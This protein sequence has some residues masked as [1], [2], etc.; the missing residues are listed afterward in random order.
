LE[1]DA[2]VTILICV[3]DHLL[4]L[5]SRETFSN[6]LTNFS[7]LLNTKGTLIVFVKDFEQLLKA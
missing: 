4:D 1:A 7:E 3:F 5:S 2:T 6:A